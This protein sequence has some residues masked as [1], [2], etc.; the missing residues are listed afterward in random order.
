MHNL[1]LKLNRALAAL[2]AVGLLATAGLPGDAHALTAGLQDVIVGLHGNPEQYLHNAGQLGGLLPN[3]SIPL[4]NPLG[5]ANVAGPAAVKWGLFSADVQGG[6]TFLFTGAFTKP[7]ADWTQAEMDN[8]FPFNAVNIAGTWMGLTNQGAGTNEF[9]GSGNANSFTGSNLWN[10]LPESFGGTHAVNAGGLLGAQLFLIQGTHD[11][12][13]GE[14]TFQQIG[15]AMVSQDGNTL[16]VSANPIPLPAAV[17]L[18]GTGLIG[19][20][21]VAR[22]KLTGQG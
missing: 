7:L 17:V 15:F 10:G 1:R 14:K 16:H 12:N 18:F 2:G 22:R 19:L 11:F 4:N 21:G 13:S 9:L 6:T 3:S 5:N 8:S 20:V